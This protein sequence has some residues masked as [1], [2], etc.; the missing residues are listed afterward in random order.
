MSSV[1]RMQHRTDS[2][3]QS[4]TKGEELLNNA[5]HCLGHSGRSATLNA[6]HGR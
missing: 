1:G 6:N 2:R 3:D 4:L 5:T